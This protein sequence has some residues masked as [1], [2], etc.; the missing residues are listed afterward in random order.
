MGIVREI[1]KRQKRMEDAR[2]PYENMMDWNIKVAVP[3]REK[4]TKWSVSNTSHNGVTNLGFADTTGDSGQL[5]GTG[6]WDPTASASLDTWKNGVLGWHTPRA[7]TWFK[8]QA[9]ERAIRGNRSILR[10]LQEVDVLLAEALERSNY[11]DMKGIRLLDS[12]GIGPSY[13]FADELVGSGKIQWR[14]PH[15]RQFW[16]E[17]DFW[18]IVNKMH[19]RYTLPLREAKRTFGSDWMS[20]SQQDTQK[21][22]PDQPVNI[23]Q[24]I[25]KNYKFDPD[26]DNAGRNRPWLSHTISLDSGVADEGGTLMEQSGYNTVNPIPWLLNRST[27]E[28]Y[29]RGVVGQFLIEIMTS[30][31]LMRD[32]LMASQQAVRPSILALDT[33][34]RK[35]NPKPGGYTW[36]D[37]NDFR[38]SGGL[39][40][41]MKLFENVEWPFT[42]EIIDRFQGVIK[43]RFGVPFFNLMDNLGGRDRV[44]AEEIVQ[45][46]AERAIL[47][48]PFLG[49]LNV[50]TDQEID[51]VFE[52]EF[53]AGR[54]P[55]PPTELLVA[56][57]QRIDIQYTG[58]L[59]QLIRQYYEVNRIQAAVASLAFL[60]DI[61]DSIP[62]NY[63]G[64]VFAQELLKSSNAP[65]EGIIPLQDVKQARAVI[66]QQNA[67]QQMIENAKQLENILPKLD[68]KPE[69]GSP[70]AQL[71][72]AV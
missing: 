22:T 13:M 17:L 48:T 60:I 10:W 23:I 58:P 49:T 50:V 2:Q 41:A 38:G 53:A 69:A 47:M 55:P 39:P 36:V 42:L 9:Q 65:I 21:D 15:P 30:N 3:S 34:K 46:Q 12:G 44:T 66:A 52:I 56:Q 27:H 61:D 29:P 64:D 5:K 43:Q 67:Q 11:Y 16:H 7:T 71:E 18:G 6:I 4:V 72:G 19:Y 68:K 33:L 59:T 35:L 24:A 63:D 37:K 8:G 25:Y 28:L 45:R 20:Q 26:S 40:P 51:R 54:I 57:N 70:V 32:M 14:V 62:L 1:I 31:Y